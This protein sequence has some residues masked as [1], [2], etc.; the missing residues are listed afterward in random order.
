MVL[1]IEYGISSK[2]KKNEEYNGDSY[3]VGEENGFFI[4]AIADGLGHGIYAN[5]AS[6]LAVDYITNNLVVP[7]EELIFGCHQALRGSRGVALS[8]AKIIFAEGGFEF[9]GV[10][11]VDCKVHSKESYHPIT[12]PGIVGYN[13]RKVKTFKYQIQEG[14]LICLYSDGISSKFDLK[15]FLELDAQA[16]ADSISNFFARELDDST[17]MI[18]KCLNKDL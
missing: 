15:K 16:M 2:P 7:L 3:F 5:D 6:S 13:L 14:D 10:G 11:N 12:V 4:G 1:K 18:L 17:V 9:A 8:I